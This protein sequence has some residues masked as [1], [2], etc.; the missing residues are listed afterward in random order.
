M[1]NTTQLSKQFGDLKAVDKISL[2][3]VDNSI[4]GLAGNFIDFIDIDYAL[5]SS[6]HVEL[7]VLK[8]LKKN[9]LHILAYI[10]GFGERCR[11]GNGKRHFEDLGERARQKRLTAPRRAHKENITLL[12]F[13][14]VVG[15]IGEEDSLVVV[16]HGYREDLLGLILSDDV[17]IEAAFNLLGRK[18]DILVLFERIMRHGPVISLHKVIAGFD[19]VITDGDIILNDQV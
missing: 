19:A 8:K 5:G 14:I 3:I 17:F 1:I 18:K 2:Q 9:I 11:I 7:G 4:F 6:L 16:M 12:D 15:L 10:S 13:H